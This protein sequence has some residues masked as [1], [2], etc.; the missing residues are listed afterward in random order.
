M[1]AAAPRPAPPRGP[2]R[3]TVAVRAAEADDQDGADHRDRQREALL[4][5]GQVDQVHVRNAGEFQANDVV[6]SEQELLLPRDG[7]VL[8]EGV[9]HP[10]CAGE[11]AVVRPNAL[12]PAHG[13]RE[14]SGRLVFARNGP[15]RP[16]RRRRQVTSSRPTGDGGTTR[17]PPSPSSPSRR[18]LSAS[19]GS[20]GAQTNNSSR[21]AAGNRSGPRSRGWRSRRR[22]P[23]G[24][25]AE[26]PS[27]ALV[28]AGGSSDFW[29]GGCLC[30]FR[31]GRFSF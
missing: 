29:P 6:S 1:A 28:R 31:V 20:G 27:I 30:F 7:P 25:A 8:G 11:L 10:R 18:K 2:P 19:W 12:L 24:P 21:V 17:P 13:P 22:R 16:W 5:V 26:K 14:A 9:V 15:S 23:P 3:A 4:R